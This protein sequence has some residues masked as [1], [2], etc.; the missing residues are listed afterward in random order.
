MP[1]DR[2]LP[3]AVS[4][5]MRNVTHLFALIFVH[6]GRI[7]NSKKHLVLT[8]TWLCPPQPNSVILKI[9]RNIRYNSTHVKSLSTTI[10][11]PERKVM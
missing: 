7:I 8:L 5:L 11:T 1:S 9:T 2:C 10:I 3:I 4:S 6:A